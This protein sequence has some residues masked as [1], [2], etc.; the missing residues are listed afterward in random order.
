[1]QLFIILM[2]SI[3]DRI[4]KVAV[5]SYFYMIIKQLSILLPPVNLILFKINS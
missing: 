3:I 1:M 5:K 2:I 4:N